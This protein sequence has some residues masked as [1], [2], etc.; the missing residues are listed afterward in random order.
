MKIFFAFPITGDRS[1]LDNAKKIVELVESLGHEVTTKIFLDREKMIL[2]EENLAPRDKYDLDIKWLLDSDILIGEISTPSYGMG[3][4]VGYLLG[5]T[6]KK[7]ILL[8]QKTHHNNI[9]PM[10][11]G[12]THP[13]CKVFQYADLAQ[14]EEFLKNEL[15][16]AR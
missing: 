12:N 2:Q 10:A 13:N 6:D 16:A 4:E 7:S 9:T 14:L 5:A 11:T 1:L 15:G 3:F 8:Y